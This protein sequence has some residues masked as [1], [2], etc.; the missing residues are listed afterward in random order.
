M[1][2]D[3]RNVKRDFGP[4]PLRER[5]EAKGLKPGDLVRASQGPPDEFSTGLINHKMVARAM[6]GRRL[7]PK[8]M[9]KVVA[10]YNLAAGEPATERDLFNYLPSSRQQRDQR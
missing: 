10:A 2:E 7:T 1:D 9:R 5:M 8:T 3:N 6:K 4:Q